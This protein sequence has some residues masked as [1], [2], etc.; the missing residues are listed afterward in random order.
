MPR[1]RNFAA[2]LRDECLNGEIFYSL[3]EATV[4]IEQWR[5]QSNTIRPAILELSAASTPNIHSPIASPGSQLHDAIVS[6]PLVQNIHQV[7]LD[8]DV[9]TPRDISVKGAFDKNGLADLEFVGWHGAPPR[10]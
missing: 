6:I 3:K 2:E 5:N 4:V 8:D 7:I 1:S 9:G 10:K